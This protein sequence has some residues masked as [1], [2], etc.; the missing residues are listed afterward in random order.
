MGQ[1]SFSILE[2]GKYIHKIVLYLLQNTC[3]NFTMRII[4]VAYFDYIFLTNI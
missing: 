3:S 4:Y 1:N 2:I